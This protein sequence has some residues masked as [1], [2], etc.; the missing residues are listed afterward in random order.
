MTDYQRTLERMSQD[1]LRAELT[2]IN[3]LLEQ[4]SRMAIRETIE[5]GTSVALSDWIQSLDR[6]VLRSTAPELPSSNS[7]RGR[8][9]QASPRSRPPSP[10]DLLAKSARMGPRLAAKLVAASARSAS[11]RNG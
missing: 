2:R 9:A 7:A 1:Q 11:R 5:H 10:L 6:P 4:Q 3:A 8:A